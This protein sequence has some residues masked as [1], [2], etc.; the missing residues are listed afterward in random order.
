L[1]EIIA[2]LLH[3][4]LPIVL[5]AAVG[6]IMQRRLALDVR[7]V[8]R[9]PLYVLTPCLA[10]TTIATSELGAGDLGRMA[11]IS[12][13]VA[14]AMVLLATVLAALL[15]LPA[16]ERGALQL[17]LAFPNA[18]NFGLSVCYFAFG[19]AGL[20]LA[21]IFFLT[22][23]ILSNTLGIYLA[24]LGGNAAGAGAALRSI[25][26]MPLLYG[27]ILGIVVRATQIAVPDTIMKAA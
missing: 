9:L 11:S 18:G 2:I 21:M 5:L 23:S 24:S 3:T 15:R 6:Y 19:D 26:G 10:F 1:T 16:K 27:A 8:S 7:S 20:N 12:V 25:L 17:A 4:I 13:L 22:S 14:C